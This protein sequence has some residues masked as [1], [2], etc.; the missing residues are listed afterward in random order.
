MSVQPEALDAAEP[1]LLRDDADGIATL[2]LNRP[3]SGNS[4]SH[5]LVRDLQAEVHRI[6]GDDTVRVVVIAAS[7]RLFCTGH[8]LKE[9]LATTS[10]EEKRAANLVCNRMMRSIV[11]SPKPVI[12]KV[13]GTATAAGC[14]LVASCDLA[15]ASTEARFATPGVNIGLWC[16]TPQ[17]A[18]S[19]A[20]SRKHAMQMLL[21]GK[22]IDAATAVRFGLINEAVPAD[23]LD[24]T[25]TE[26]ATVIASKSPFAVALGKRSFYRQYEMDRGPAYD[27]VADQMVRAFQA[28]D[29]REGIA[30][31]LEKRPPVW[32]GR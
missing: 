25:V 24:A 22:L 7:G 1:V 6:A 17:V 12:A 31:F 5:R 18:L 15:I 29:A 3:A 28:E 27:Y 4:L 19:R 30:A 11:D 14:E 2:T 10:G 16:L 26:L 32:R 13:Q 20:V 21:T 23:A 9:S 8:D